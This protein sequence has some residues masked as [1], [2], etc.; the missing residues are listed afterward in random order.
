MVAHIDAGGSVV[1]RDA[2]E[3]GES[4]LRRAVWRLSGNTGSQW[5]VITRE[6]SRSIS[7][8]RERNETI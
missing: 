1:H 5:L 3:H 2:K 8:P 7:C 4:Q 6:S